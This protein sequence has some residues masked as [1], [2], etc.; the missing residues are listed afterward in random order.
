MIVP[1]L[2]AIVICKG[3]D[4]TKEGKDEMSLKKE[5]RDYL[6][7]PDSL[8]L[9]KHNRRSKENVYEKEAEKIKAKV[10]KKKDGKDAKKAKKNGKNVPPLHLN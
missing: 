4:M 9:K 8:P 5:K 6:A 1:A 3:I 2:S 7:N 10:E